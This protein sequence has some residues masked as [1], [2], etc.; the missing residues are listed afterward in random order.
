MNGDPK[1]YRIIGASLIVLCVVCLAVLQRVPLIVM[2]PTL[3]FFAWRWWE[4]HK[5]KA[6]EMQPAARQIAL[7]KPQELDVIDTEFEMIS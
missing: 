6:P 3:V 4:Q 1:I 2:L 5:N 7:A